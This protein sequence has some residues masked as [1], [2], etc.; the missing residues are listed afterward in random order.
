MG[1]IGGL[2]TFTI[3]KPIIVSMFSGGLDSTGSLWKLLSSDE[4][5]NFHI[6]VHHINILNVES[7]EKA[8]FKAVMKM[9]NSLNNNGFKFSFSQGIQDF[10][11]LHQIGFPMDMD[12]CAFV[13]GQMV[14][15]IPNI[16]HIAMG[17]TISDMAE[18]GLDFSNRMERAQRIF[19]NSIDGVSNPSYIFPVVKYS[20]KEVFDMLPDYLKNGFWTCRSPGEKDGKFHPCDICH[21][22]QSLKKHGIIQQII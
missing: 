14:R 6:H 12:I 2:N 18:G 20:K 21:S 5:K 8:E 13:A 22:C 16:Q 17:R 11:Y 1:I 15:C 7:R 10:R 19:K 3:A 9:L 4:Y